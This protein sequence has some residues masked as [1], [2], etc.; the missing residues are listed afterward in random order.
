MHPRSHESR[1]AI[2]FSQE[3]SK[4]AVL[5]GTSFVRTDKDNSLRY[6]IVEVYR[7]PD[8]VN[9]SV[10]VE[11]DQAQYSHFGKVDIKVVTEVET[12]NS[13]R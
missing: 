3:I 4:E 5:S 9:Y 7:S 1:G 8:V 10:D 6:P 11:A 2:T 13:T 12:D